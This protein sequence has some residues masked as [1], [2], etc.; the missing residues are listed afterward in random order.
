MKQQVDSLSPFAEFIDKT[1][2]MPNV[3]DEILGNLDATDVAVCLRVNKS[4][5]K[6]VASCLTWNS[7]LRHK[8][9]A[10]ATAAA[11][12]KG[13]LKAEFELEF[14]RDREAEIA[15]ESDNREPGDKLF[16]SEEGYAEDKVVALDGVWYHRQQFTT[17]TGVFKL[18]EN[19]HHAEINTKLETG[20]HHFNEMRVYPTSS[21]QRVF[22]HNKPPIDCSPRFTSP[23]GLNKDVGS[24]DKYTLAEVHSNV[25]KVIPMAGHD[26]AGH[27][28]LKHERLNL[29]EKEANVPFFL[30]YRIFAM[31]EKVK[32]DDKDS[33]GRGFGWRSRLV[34]ALLNDEG[35]FCKSVNL[36]QFEYKEYA[37]M[38]HISS[39]EQVKK[40]TL[41]F[42]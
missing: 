22:F 7:K 30:R 32:I 16:S 1:A 38:L 27:C 21:A 35:V 40:F 18:D 10:S 19:L 17:F 20:E 14:D 41:Q 6:V 3:W 5:R 28:E 25:A 2:L 23:F 29:L 26:F 24:P 4:L 15:E 39:K 11:I 8:M 31:P 9:D 12:R 42:P 37:V 13:F 36:H 33:F 34:M